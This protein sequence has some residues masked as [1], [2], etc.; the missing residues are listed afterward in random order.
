MVGLVRDEKC[1]Q[2]QVWATCFACHTSITSTAHDCRMDCSRG[3]YY[4]LLVASHFILSLGFKKKFHCD[5]VAKM[6]A[7]VNFETCF[8]CH[9]SNTSTAHDCRMDCSRGFYY[10]LLFKSHKIF[11]LRFKKK[12]Q[13]DKVAKMHD[14]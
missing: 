10:I 11:S 7:I 6:H 5:K 12:F 14:F 1:M 13:C 2:L 3:F 9:T 8:A 4:I